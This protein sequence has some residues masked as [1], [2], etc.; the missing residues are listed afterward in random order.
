M[1]GQIDL[2]KA[3]AAETFG[4]LA[5]PR[6]AKSSS[7]RKA[8]LHPTAAQLKTLNRAL[9]TILEFARESGAGRRAV[10]AGNVSFTLKAHDTEEILSVRKLVA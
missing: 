10:K 1:N 9:C 2:E 3:G 7:S 4:V 6:H 5:V 8:R